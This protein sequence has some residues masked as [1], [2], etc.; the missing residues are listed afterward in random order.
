M[1][2]KNLIQ[3][4]STIIIV[5]GFI[6]L[7]LGSGESSKSDA[8]KIDINSTTEISNFLQGKWSWTDY[9]GG[10]NGNTRYRIEINGNKITVLTCFGNIH[11]PFIANKPAEVLEFSLG[12]PTRDVD[13]RKCRFFN[14]RY[15]QNKSLAFRALEPIWVVVGKDEPYI[16]NGGGGIPWD[17]GWE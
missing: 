4:L 11:D 5:S 2:R 6:I 3:V 14:Y 13:G 1:K 15:D 7:A 8:K 12:E 10:A 9:T 17:R 16:L